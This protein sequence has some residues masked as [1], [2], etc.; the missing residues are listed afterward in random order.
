V[1]LMPVRL[2]VCAL[3]L[4]APAV[5]AQDGDALEQL[6]RMSLEDLGRAEVTSVSKS[7]QSLESAA[8]AIF[9]I[10]RED[11]RRSGVPSLAEALRLAP[12]LQVI[13]L[14]SSSYQVAARGFGGNQLAQNFSNKLLMLI[15]GRSVYSPLY[16]GIFLDAQDVLLDDV[17][18]IE[19]ISGPGATLWGANAMNGVINVITRKASETSGALVRAVGGNEEQ[20]LE[21][22]FGSPAGSA[23]DYRVYAKAFKR[24][25]LEQADGA[26]A[27]D[28]WKKTQGGFRLD[29]ADA[30]DV[31]TV[32][33]DLY[34]AQQDVPGVDGDGAISGNDLLARWQRTSGRSQW[35]VQV[36]VDRTERES[37]F[38]GAFSLDT[39]DLEI[40]QRLDLGRHSV[41][42][43]GGQRFSRYQITNTESL[44]LLRPRRTLELGNLFAE[45]TLSIGEAVKLTAGLKLEHD[46]YSGW[47]GLPDLRLSWAPRENMLL[48]AAGSRAIRS[49]TPFDVDVVE[50]LGT[51][52]YVT[53]NPDFRSEKVDA[54]ELGYRARP[55]DALAFS[56]VA[57]FNRYDDLRTIEVNPDT[58]FLP[59]RWGNRMSGDTYG[60]EAWA[61]VQLTDSW[62]VSPGLRTLRKRLQFDEGASGLLGLVQAGNDPDYQGSLRS[63]LD[64]A[65]R[66]TFDLHLRYMDELPNPVT[67]GFYELSARVGWRLSSELEV[68]VSG[69]DLLD[70]R[71][72]EYNSPEFG[73]VGR[74]VFAELR[75]AN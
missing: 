33:G 45:D 60:F 28:A 17:E 39:Y 23:L 6:R 53:G 74:S 9:V 14:T 37:P 3:V 29:W 57:F 2:I 72:Q 65:S 7:A 66:G 32:S 20:A 47:A 27:G 24:G 54:Y 22:R 15:D 36:Y 70:R 5:R 13:R 59:L 62:R 69:F 50:K 38:G 68:A 61:D 67:D 8:A 10:T 26:S 56:A 35:H 11:L 43:G 51:V 75:W 46:P 49:P 4:C 42:F 34:R 48:W 1:K 21:A 71:H 19:V 30:D 58:G 40:Q 31:L 41:V 73:N 63:T 55:F 44:L 18:R 12:N 52:V 16:A 25:A 64:F